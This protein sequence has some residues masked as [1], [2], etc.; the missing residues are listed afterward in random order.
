MNP[1]VPVGTTIAVISR[2]APVRAVTVTSDVI[3]V[4]E[5]VMNALAP[6]ITQSSPS[7]RARVRLAPASLPASGSVSP[8]PASVRPAQRSGN[9]RWRCSSVPYA[10]IGAAPSPTAASRVIAIDES[11]RATSSMATHSVVKSAPEPPYSTGNGSPNRPS[12][13]IAWTASTGNSWSRSHRSACG[14]DLLLREV[15]DDLAE[16]FVFLGEVEV[17][18]RLASTGTL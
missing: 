11:T 6:S 5:F 4:P 16:G 8:N 12:R 7:R 3:G 17:H 10:A 13:P 15:A 1:G 18:F 14:A 2:A 9:H